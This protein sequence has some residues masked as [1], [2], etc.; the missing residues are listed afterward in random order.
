[1]SQMPDSIYLHKDDKYNTLGWYH[2]ESENA[3]LAEHDYDESVMEDYVEYTPVYRLEEA[4]GK[5]EK[6]LALT[7]KDIAK[8]DALILEANNE[9][10]VDYSKEI[11][12]EQFYTEVLN[13]FN[14]SKEEQK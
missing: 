2:A 5:A 7:W 13:R 4:V 12:R 1:M 14:K 3:I 9:F 8:I 6:D 11:S 10:A